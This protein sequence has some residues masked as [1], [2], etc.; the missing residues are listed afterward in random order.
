MYLYYYTWQPLANKK[1]L[2]ITIG[3][4]LNVAGISLLLLMNAPTAFMQTP[5]R[6]DGSIAGIA[7]FGEWAWINNF[8]WWPLNYHRLVGNLTFGGYLVGMIGAFMYLFSSNK[9]DREYY[10]WQGYLGN[11]LGIG[12]MIPLPAMGYILAKELYSYDA[13]IGMYIMSDRLSMFM[14]VQAVL[15]GFLFVGSSFYIYVSMQR[16][17][18]ADIYLK[19]VK[20]TFA[21]IIMAAAIW[22]TPRH[23]F[24]TML[25]EPGMLPE[26]MEKTEYLKMVELPG[27]RS[28]VAP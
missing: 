9:E 23:Y 18:G 2:H 24:A 14:L 10:D 25:L 27:P 12:F 5:P 26:G 16:I 8:S 22:F 11:T 15:I 20:R 4:L 3:I 21:L 7:Q 13:S 1:G 6:V 28:M 19:I 17:E